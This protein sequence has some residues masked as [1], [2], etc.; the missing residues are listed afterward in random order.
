[1]RWRIWPVFSQN[2]TSPKYVVL[3]VV[4]FH[5]FGLAH[6]RVG[7]AG[8]EFEGEDH[9]PHVLAEIGGVEVPL[10]VDAGVDEQRQLVAG[11]GCG[12]A[13]GG[14]QVGGGEDL[15]LGRPAQHC[16][17]QPDK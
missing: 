1:M 2:A 16:Q 5:R 15:G 4:R 12:A 11:L 17:Q 3:L 7:R 9:R 13:Q 14:G 10:L 6:Q 8:H